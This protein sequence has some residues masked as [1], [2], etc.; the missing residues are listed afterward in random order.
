MSS[1]ERRR[2]RCSSSSSSRPSG[3]TTLS[4]RL[5]EG[6]VATSPS[7]DIKLLSWM[8]SRGRSTLSG[9]RPRIP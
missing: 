7:R 4:R 2:S 5:S 6:P 1:A 8:I 9:P 3:N